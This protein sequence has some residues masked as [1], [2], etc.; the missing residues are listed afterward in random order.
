MCQRLP[1]MFV[2][3]VTRKYTG[4]FC[5]SKWFCNAPDQNPSHIYVHQVPNGPLDKDG[6]DEALTGSKPISQHS[7]F[8]SDSDEGISQAGNNSSQLPPVVIVPGLQNPRTEE[9]LDSKQ[10]ANLWIPLQLKRFHARVWSS[11]GRA[12][13]WKDKIDPRPFSRAGSMGNHTKVKQFMLFYLV[14]L[15]NLWLGTGQTNSSNLF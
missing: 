1:K 4:S 12:G 3:V 13:L 9:E 8:F 14:K 10:R 2:L 11:L 6:L 15:L 7:S 5:L